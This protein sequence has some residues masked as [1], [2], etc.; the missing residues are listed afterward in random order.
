MNKEVIVKVNWVSAEDGG[1]KRIPITEY[2]T[3]AHFH[4]DEDGRDLERNSKVFFA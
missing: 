4:S 1:K 2:S 3:A